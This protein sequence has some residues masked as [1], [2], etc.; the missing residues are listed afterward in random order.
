M[1]VDGGFDWVD[2][3]DVAE[4]AVAAAERAPPGGRYIVGGRWASMAEL[5]ELACVFTEPV[6]PHDVPSLP[7]A[8]VGADIHG[9]LPRH[10]KGAPVHLLH[11]QG[12]AGNRVVS[13]RARHASSIAVPGAGGDHPRYLP[14]VP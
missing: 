6:P 12:A 13:Q 7:G 9:L 3:R 1:L 4:T 11:P 8:R 2:V 14:V 10:G 5:A